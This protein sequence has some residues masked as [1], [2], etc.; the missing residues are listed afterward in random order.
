M[1]TPSQVVK[2]AVP[3]EERDECGP[4]IRARYV[5]AAASATGVCA[6][7]D[8]TRERSSGARSAV[9]SAE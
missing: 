3:R 1:K 6:G 9:Q 7:H 5:N 2:Q 4:C 8:E